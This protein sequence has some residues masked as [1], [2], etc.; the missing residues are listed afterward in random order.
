VARATSSVGGT[1]SKAEAGG[2][3]RAGERDGDE[4]PGARGIAAGMLTIVIVL[5]EKAKR[6]VVG[7]TS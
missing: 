4:R 5:L 6:E 7:R 1:G 3:V 2:G